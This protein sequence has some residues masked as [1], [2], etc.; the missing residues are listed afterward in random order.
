MDYIP[1]E[2]RSFVII[3]AVTICIIMT[4]TQ[5]RESP[6][7]RA[8]LRLG[9]KCKNTQSL[10]WVICRLGVI[11]KTL[12]PTRNTANTSGRTR[13][14]IIINLISHDRTAFP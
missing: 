3:G 7:N 9:V 6:R 5:P 11:R 13:L 2:L 4:I 10:S 14:Q 12:R 1:S 8:P